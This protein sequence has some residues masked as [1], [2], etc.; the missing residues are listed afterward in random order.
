MNKN[1]LHLENIG[2]LTLQKVLIE[3][4]IPSLFVCNDENDKT[5]LCLCTDSSNYPYHYLIVETD[6]KT[7]IEM[8]K[9]KIT[10][11]E[12]FKAKGENAYISKRNTQ[13]LVESET[14]KIKIKDVKD[15][16]LPLKG[17][18]FELSNRYIK[19][20]IQELM[21]QNSTPNKFEGYAHKIQ[22]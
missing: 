6:K 19:K 12:A 20:Y 9:N 14:L 13:Q 2:Y 15:M 4:D 16:D 1:Y 18:Y 3:F 22:T 21:E 17:A 11:Y 10:M 5:Y 8:L 7:L